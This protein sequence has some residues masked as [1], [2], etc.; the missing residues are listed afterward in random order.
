VNLTPL[1]N[2]VIV[3]R[4]EMSGDRTTA[5]G[6]Y[7]P[8]IAQEKPQTATVVAVGPGLMQEDGRYLLMHVK[9]GNKV[10]LGK[11]SGYDVTIGNSVYTVLAET[12]ILGVFND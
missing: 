7:I 2:R 5:S 1:G 4:D 11:Y 6:L 8:D 9:P 10:M 12:D 3:Q